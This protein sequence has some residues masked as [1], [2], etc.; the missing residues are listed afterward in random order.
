MFRRHPLSFLQEL[1]PFLQIARHLTAPP[2][3][4]SGI[5]REMSSL[6]RVALA[7]A[8]APGTG[9]KALAAAIQV[10]AR[11]SAGNWNYQW[12]PGPYPRT[13]EERLAAAKKYNLEPEDYKPFPEDGYLGMGLGDYPDLPRVRFFFS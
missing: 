5:G 4:V 9:P 7:R 8:R 1:F 11:R 6:A 12:M 10:M 2:F 13:K 3:G